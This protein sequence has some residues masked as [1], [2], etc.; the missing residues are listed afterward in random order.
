MGNKS[1]S[2]SSGPRTRVPSFDDAPTLSSR[3]ASLGSN[4]SRRHSRI[5]SAHDLGAR[6]RFLGA[7]IAGS[8]V[9]GSEEDVSTRGGVQ[10][11]KTQGVA[12]AAA[13]GTD[14][15][16][17]T[18][19]AAGSR[20]TRA[21]SAAFLDISAIDASSLATLPLYLLDGSAWALNYHTTDKSK[22]VMI[23]LS[24]KH[25]LKHDGAFSLFVVTNGVVSGSMHAVD[26][27][28]ILGPL[29][30]DWAP[31]RMLR[32][33]LFTGALL[34]G[35]GAES[36]HLVLRRR[37]YFPESPAT[38]EAILGNDG[39]SMAFTLAFIDARFNFRS[40]FLHTTRAQLVETAAL[41][42]QG[43]CWH[44]E[45]NKDD[46]GVLPFTLFDV[47]LLTEEVLPSTM[48]GIRHRDALIAD[49][50]KMWRSGINK[51]SEF[52]AESLFCHKL[53]TWTDWYGSILFPCKIVSGN[54]TSDNSSSGGG[55]LI[56]SRKQQF[57][58]VTGL[59]VYVMERASDVEDGMVKVWSFEWT[60]VAEWAG[61]AA[62]VSGRLVLR[63]H[64]DGEEG[65]QTR[66]VVLPTPESMYAVI[67]QMIE[68]THITR[69]GGALDRAGAE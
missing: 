29:L 12:G 33:D 39:S 17:P 55:T 22:H 26:D 19:T 20:H 45:S 6:G 15:D 57:L 48:A 66:T 13:G 18:T 58:A 28:A 10:A 23:R 35:S 68:Y 65:T 67:D 8:T 36:K 50:E 27:D 61:E 44:M 53:S 11:G 34:G 7:R 42:Y 38:R 37:I 24:E 5:R 47:D 56:G 52:D 32:S 30:S 64:V 62:G 43:A 54:S 51:L 25:G 49:I 59:G 69:L 4:S 63:V 60:R 41:L 2:S 14:E 46:A 31:N 3:R 1:S 16:E 40:G 21:K 9:F